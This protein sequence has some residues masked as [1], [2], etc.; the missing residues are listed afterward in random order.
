M[1]L[2]YL[3]DTDCLESGSRDFSKSS[4]AFCAEVIAVR[5]PVRALSELAAASIAKAL[6]LL[7]LDASPVAKPK[8]SPFPRAVSWSFL[9]CK[10]RSARYFE[11]ALSSVEGESDLI[12]ASKAS[13]Y[14]VFGSGVA[15]GGG[16]T[17]DP[18][19]AFT[20]AP[21]GVLVSPVIGALGSTFCT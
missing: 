4:R 1:P 6:F 5:F 20:V 16:V 12:Y 7:T 14:P 10:V 13:L 2:P 15:G 21:D 11:A 3:S 19:V 17:S 18:V 8:V 9:L